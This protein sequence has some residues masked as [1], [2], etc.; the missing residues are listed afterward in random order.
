L[1]ESLSTVER[2]ATPLEQAT[3]PSLEALQA[4][5]LGRKQAERGAPADAVLFLKRAIELDSNFALDYA[6]LSIL[7]STTDSDAGAQYATKAFE[8]R[9][10]V[11]ERE[12]LYI[13][14][15]YYEMV[16]GELDKT[17][18]HVASATAA[19]HNLPVLR[20]AT[21]LAFC[22]HTRQAQG[23]IEDVRARFP[24]DTLIQFV[25]IPLASA[26]IAINDGNPGAAIELLQSAAPYE[27]RSPGVIYVRGLAYLQAHKPAE[28]A[29]E[30]QKILDRGAVFS[31][32]IGALAHL[33][34][35]RAYAL[36]GDT[37]K[38]RA[39]Y[40]DFLTLWKD[41]DPG[42]PILIAAK[43]EYSKLK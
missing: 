31:L 38:A 9:N 6:G 26:A 1:G 37:A 14:T 28:A 3:T 39:A 11:S 29:T 7:Y 21:A 25:R 32:P 30:F 16:T 27:K 36:Q 40:Q 22:G 42:I 18:E 20:D 33:G 8:L 41:A 2:L 34:L 4:Y 19:S 5:P 23:L 35:G 13:A 10:H 12:R 43:A 17:I 24:K 15:V